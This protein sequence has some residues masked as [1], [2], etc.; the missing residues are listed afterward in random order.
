MYKCPVC[1]R[2]DE[3]EDGLAEVC[4]LALNPKPIKVLTKTV[5][6]IESA[7]KV[8]ICRKCGVLMTHLLEED[9]VNT[10]TTTKSI[11]KNGKTDVAM[12]FHQT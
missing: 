2:T 12:G 11:N 5:V 3:F 10:F 6:S 8:Y 9:E 4:S 1:G 7:L